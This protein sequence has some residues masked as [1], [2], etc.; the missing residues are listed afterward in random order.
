MHSFLSSF[1]AICFI[2]HTGLR[3]CSLSAPGS[4]LEDQSRLLIGMKEAAVDSFWMQ[5]MRILSKFVLGWE[6]PPES[7]KK[8]LC[9]ER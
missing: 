7:S 6:N 4:S 9:N 5:K 3:N 8:K 2:N 1:T